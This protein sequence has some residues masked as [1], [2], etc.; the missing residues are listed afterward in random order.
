MTLTC[1][2]GLGDKSSIPGLGVEK[3]AKDVLP[4]LEKPLIVEGLKE[5]DPG[6]MEFLKGRLG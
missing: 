3:G 5:V 1:A 2:G 4:K 6:G